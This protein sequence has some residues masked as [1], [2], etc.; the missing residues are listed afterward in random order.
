[1]TATVFAWIAV[2]LIVPVSAALLV[3]RDWRWM[4]GLLATLYL[5]AFIL[6]AQHWPLGMAVV[7]LVSGW[8]VV[9]ALGMSR[10]G[11]PLPEEELEVPILLEGSAFR[12]FG[13]SISVL[14]AVSV[15]PQIESLIPGIG[16]PITI[17]SLVLIG[18]GLL[19]LGMTSNVLRVTLGLLTEL[20]GFEILYAAVESSIL[21]AALL[22]VANL[23]LALVGSYLLI[24]SVQ[25]EEEQ[26]L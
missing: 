3:I 4:L 12:L 20:S 1:M 25:V 22:A 2:G 23:G 18:T 5:A 16:L 8:M 15:G 17:G 11:L 19:Q 24:H 10:L 26:Q 7:K 6:V 21:V 14:I 9:A 13:A